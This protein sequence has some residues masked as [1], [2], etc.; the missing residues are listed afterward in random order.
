MRALGPT[1]GTISSPTQPDN[2]T[3]FRG[4]IFMLRCDRNG[5]ERLKSEITNLQLDTPELAG[6][7]A[8]GVQSRAVQSTISDFGFESLMSPW[9]TTK[10]QNSQQ[11]PGRNFNKLWLFWKE[12]GFSPISRFLLLRRHY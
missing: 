5:H 10:H 8:D 2:T 11:S 9:L 12:V 6:I 3:P 1:G 4:S 7:S